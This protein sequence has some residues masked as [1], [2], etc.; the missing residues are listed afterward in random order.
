MSNKEQQKDVRR[1]YRQQL[2]SGFKGYGQP[3]EWN[4]NSEKTVNPHQETKLP[5]SKSYTVFI[6]VIITKTSMEGDEH[7]YSISL[8]AYTDISMSPHSPRS[9]RATKPV[10]SI[11]GEAGKKADKIPVVYGVQQDGSYSLSSTVGLPTIRAMQV[12]Y[13]NVLGTLDRAIQFALQQQEDAQSDDD[14]GQRVKGSF[15][16]KNVAKNKAR[17][18]SKKIRAKIRAEATPKESSVLDEAIGKILGDG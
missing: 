12:I 4:G 13:S 15:S 8:N 2:L 9:K 14:T 5:K 11:P 6:P 16:P 17:G 10:I 18:R 7:K 1:V 3:K